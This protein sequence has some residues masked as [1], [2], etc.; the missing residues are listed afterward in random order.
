MD[1]TSNILVTGANGLVGS[2]VLKALVQD[3]YRNLYGLIRSEEKI[4]ALTEYNDSVN[5]VIGDILNLPSLEDAIEGKDIVVH[6]AASVSYDPRKEPQIFNVNNNGTGNVMNV[7]AHFNVK[8]IIHLSS[9]AAL[10]RKKYDFTIDENAAWVNSPY[11]TAY[12]KSKYLG[13]QHAWRTHYEGTPVTILNP[14]VI[15]GIGD[16]NSSSLQFLPKLKKGSPFYPIGSTGFVDVEDVAKAVLLAFNEHFNGQRFILNSQN[17][18]FHDFF[19]LITQKIGAKT[20]SIPLNNF[21]RSLGWRIEAIRSRIFKTE[22]ILTKETAQSSSLKV[23]YDNTK[24]IEMLNLSYKPFDQ[25]IDQ[26]TNAFNEEY[27]GQ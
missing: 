20:P 3:G 9:I 16:W 15:L 26:I 27:K 4:K 17:I 11:N 24:S 7:A 18:S 25:T 8:K 13:E 10:G 2:H 21:W 14:S 12:A 1:K 22:P 23:A 5:W 19:K 6:T